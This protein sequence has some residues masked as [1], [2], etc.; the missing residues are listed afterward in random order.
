MIGVTI[1]IGEG[2][3]ECAHAS[4]RRMEDKTGFPCTVIEREPLLREGVH[5]SWFK[6]VIHEMFSHC[7][8]FLYFDADI[9]ALKPWN[10]EKIFK[11]NH[12]RLCAVL[13]NDPAMAKEVRQE[14]KDIGILRGTYLNAG[15][16]MFGREHAP[17]FESTWAKR[18]SWHRW[19]DQGAFNRSIHDLRVP[20]AILPNEYNHMRP[21]DASTSINMHYCGLGGNWQELKRAQDEFFSPTEGRGFV[22]R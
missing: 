3:F 12:R 9:L 20:V 5:P 13:D 15:L 2:W 1:G 14:E 7:N 16:F 8:E 11:D 17:L 19:I 22:A 21:R 6:H 10:P 18:P 4:A